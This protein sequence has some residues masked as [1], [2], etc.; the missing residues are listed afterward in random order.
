[1][2]QQNQQ[3]N[4]P[5][6]TRNNLSLQLSPHQIKQLQDRIQKVGVLTSQEMECL[7]K[8][9]KVVKELSEGKIRTAGKETRQG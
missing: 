1:M 7:E 6:L 3:K 4:H 8:H 5:G 2:D 9:V